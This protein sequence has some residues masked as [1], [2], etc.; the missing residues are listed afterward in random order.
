MSR[1][2]GP[3]EDSGAAAGR[4]LSWPLILGLGS[5][6]LLTPLVQLTGLGEVLGQPTTVLGILAVVAVAWIGSVGF[7]RVPRPV[8]TL[9][10]AGAVHGAL[11]VVVGLVF[12]A[13][14]EWGGAAAVVAVL[15]E[16][17]WSTVLGG[18]AGLLALVIQRAT[19][20]QP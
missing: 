18:V 13:S 15:F 9:A 6:A 10:L 14:R 7:G 20:R 4:P 1:N 2:A 5:L 17:G 19:G 8:L 12:G 11:L 16:L 3:P